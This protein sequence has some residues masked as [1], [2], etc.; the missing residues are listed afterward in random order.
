MN[1]LSTIS[2]DKNRKRLVLIFAAVQVLAIIRNYGTNL[3]SFYWY[4]DFAPGVLAVLFLCN[5]VQAIKGFLNIGLFAQIGYTVVI[6]AKALFGVTLFNFVFDF[7]FTFQY[8]V[9]TIIIHLAAL[10]AFYATYTIRPTL[11]ALIYSIIILCVMFGV[12][13]LFSHPM[14]DA[15]TNFNFIFGSNMLSFIPYY[16]QL[17]VVLTFLLVVLP[18]HAFQ[19][20]AYRAHRALWVENTSD[21]QLRGV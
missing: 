11:H 19:H 4:C 5:N 16:S 6:L 9:P 7:P 18:T 8:V 1:I 14:G 2:Y 15:L 17:W 13:I 20:L 3:F 21:I 10:L 12:V